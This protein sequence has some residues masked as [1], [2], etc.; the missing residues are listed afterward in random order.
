GDRI[1]FDRAIDGL[2]REMQARIMAAFQAMPENIRNTFIINEGWRSRDYQQYLYD[3]RSG[4]GMV[5]SP[6]GSRHEAGGIFG[7][8]RAIDVDKG[9][10][11]DW[12]HAN[13]SQVGLTGIGGDYPHIQMGGG[14]NFYDA[15]NP[16]RMATVS[17]PGS[18]VAP[19]WLGPPG[20]PRPPG[21]V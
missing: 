18:P 16:V 13:G 5:A 14:R 20:T 2:S 4:R 21:E 17:S 12:L 11:L 1:G 6:G 19:G 10:A 9:P 7:Q 8:G 3:T 15:N